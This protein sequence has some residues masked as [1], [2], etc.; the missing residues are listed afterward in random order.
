MVR[1]KEKKRVDRESA[2]V[3]GLEKKK[4]GERRERTKKKAEN[5]APK[6][7]YLIV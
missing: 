1:W 6:L 5:A 7:K 4:R 2:L 3:V